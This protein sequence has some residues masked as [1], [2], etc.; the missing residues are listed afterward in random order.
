[1]LYYFRMQ[2]TDF[3]KKEN[4][5]ICAFTGHRV[6]EEDFSPLALQE[7]IDRQLKA[8][9]RV[10][11][12]GVAM[13]F[14]LIAAELVLSRLHEYPDIRLIACIPCDNQDKRYSPED[15]IRYYNVLL[16]AEQIRFSKEY[17]PGCMQRRDAFM[18]KHADV[19]IAYCKKQTGGT[20]FTVKKYL[21]YN[22][23]GEIYNL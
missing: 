12:N 22:P 23:D 7:E 6:L 19:L 1:M 16:V 11:L 17:S 5:K 3:F 18:A 20:A 15:K 8:G 14:D 4:E 2:P 13:G 9:V 10:F 21:Q